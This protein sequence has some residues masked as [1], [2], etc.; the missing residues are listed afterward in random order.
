MKRPSWIFSRSIDNRTSGL[1]LSVDR[2]N[3]D[4]RLDKLQTFP[5]MRRVIKAWLKAGVLD[6]ETLFPTEEGTPQGGVISPLLANVALHGLIKEI[7][8]H[9][10]SKKRTTKEKSA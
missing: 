2:I 10:P 8:S 3:Q 7:E 9:F 1:M 6:G 5:L 4:A